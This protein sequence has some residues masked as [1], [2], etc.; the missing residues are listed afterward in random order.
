[1]LGDEIAGTEHAKIMRASEAVIPTEILQE[2]LVEL[3][4]VC[5]DQNS[6]RAK[7]ILSKA[8]S[9]YQA[10]KEWVDPLVNH[11]ASGSNKMIKLV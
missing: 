4:R 5:K 7:T 3:S 9:G 10:H 8:V 1:L 2:Y 6:I 11:G